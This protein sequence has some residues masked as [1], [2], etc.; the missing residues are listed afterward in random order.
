MGS[1]LIV[2]A[3][4]MAGEA[5]TGL[6]APVQQC[7]E[8]NAAKVEKAVSSLPE[9]MD[10]LVTGV[11]AVPIA[12]E[13]QRQLRLRREE[14]AD[15]YRKQCDASKQSVFGN[16][17]N[18]AQSEASACRLADSFSQ[19]NPITG[20]TS[21]ESAAKPPEAIGYAARLLLDLRLARTNEKGTH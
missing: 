4:A 9:A 21:Y 14:M 3:P 2:S 11:C 1:L 12:A 17:T 18:S 13:Q 20:W 16:L 15:R 6:P 8:A 7:I 19:N 5:P 10:F